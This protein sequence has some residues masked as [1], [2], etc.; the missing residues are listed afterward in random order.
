MKSSMR[1]AIVAVALGLLWAGLAFNLSKPTDAAGYL[2]TALQA[3][4]S[5]HDGAVTVR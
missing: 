3:A 2:R 4:T 5:A 1:L